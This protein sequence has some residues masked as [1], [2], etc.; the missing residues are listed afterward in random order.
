MLHLTSFLATLKSSQSGFSLDA[1]KKNAN[2]RIEIGDYRLLSVTNLDNYDF[3]EKIICELGLNI[4]AGSGS[5]LESEETAFLSDKFNSYIKE[6][7]DVMV[8][9][10]KKNRQS[11]ISNA[12]KLQT[13][14]EKDLLDAWEDR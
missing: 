3:D 14:N 13:E 6:Y 4:I 2:A 11:M 5:P 7:N 8:R 10:Y 9:H 12:K 1:P